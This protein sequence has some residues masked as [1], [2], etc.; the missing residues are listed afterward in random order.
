MCA[1][2]VTGLVVALRRCPLNEYIIVTGPDVGRYDLRFAVLFTGSVS[3]VDIVDGLSVI[4][5]IFVTVVFTSVEKDALA[6]LKLPKLLF[7]SAAG[8]VIV[9]THEVKFSVSIFFIPR[10]PPVFALIR[11]SRL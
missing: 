3:V 10:L 4:C 2:T 7:G 5:P 6:D 11:L 1:F 9:R 8:S